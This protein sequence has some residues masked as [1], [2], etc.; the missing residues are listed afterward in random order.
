VSS[1]VTHKFN[2]YHKR[3][4][5]YSTPEDLT[6]LRHSVDTFL[7]GHH[8]T[9]ENEWAECNHD[10]ATEGEEGRSRKKMKLS[11]E[12]K[13]HEQ[14]KRLS[15]EEREE[16]HRELDEYLTLDQNQRRERSRLRWAQ[17]LRREGLRRERSRRGGCSRREGLRKQPES[18]RREGLRRQPK[19]SRRE[20]LPRQPESSRREGL[21]RQPKSSRREDLP[22]QPESSRREG[23]RRRPESSRRR[24]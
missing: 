9:L 1:E 4:M 11:E 17:G 19:S 15:H 5:K 7:K 23:L 2:L 12:G 8:E 24:Q 20:D 14:R 18:S 21:R 10:A 16:R 3:L 22:R 13:W 6:T